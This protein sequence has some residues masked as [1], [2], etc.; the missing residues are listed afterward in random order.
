MNQELSE[1]EYGRE[2]NL[3][4]RCHRQVR[5]LSHSATLPLGSLLERGLNRLARHNWSVTGG[6]GNDAGN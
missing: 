5:R 2:A 4:G 3:E 1:M 6:C